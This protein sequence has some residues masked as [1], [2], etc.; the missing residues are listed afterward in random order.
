MIASIAIGVEKTNQA[1]LNLPA[2]IQEVVK[3]IQMII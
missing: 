2:Y 1:A 3:L